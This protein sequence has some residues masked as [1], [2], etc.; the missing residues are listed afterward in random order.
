[1]SWG[2]EL[3]KIRRYLRD[4]NGRLW[5]DA[6]LMHI[7]NDI[8]Q[9][10]QHKTMAL[11]DIATQR[12][13]GLYQ[14]AYQFD[15]EWRFLSTDL[16]Q[17]YQCLTIYD[18][19]V[20][21]HRWEAQQMSG[22]AADVSDYG[23][24]FTQPWE[25][26]MGEIPGD[27]IKFRF[28]SN[29]RTLKYIAYDEK[30]IAGTTKKQIQATDPSYVVTQGLPLA[31]YPYDETDNSY[32]LYPRPATSWVNEISGDGVALYAD[33]DSEDTTTGVIA[34]R[35]GSTDSEIGI[36]V[37]IVDATSSVFMVYSV[38]PTDM[39]TVSDESDFP[40][41]MLKYIRHGTV[42]RAYG[43]NTD[44][45]IQS[46][47]DYWQ[48]RYALGI[49]FCKRYLRSRRQDRDYRLTTPGM[50]RR[51]LRHPRLPDHYPALDP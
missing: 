5:S 20:M 1:M 34:I 31:F 7:Y 23:I 4:P 2:S 15:W 35:T 50:S 14:F 49:Q 48:G 32:V 43:A 25:A 28:P 26:F 40:D 46:L 16:S 3:V 27:V 9:D 37:D 41:F 24:H 36:P 38:T 8:Q 10:F 18:D 47:A 42:S 51:R 19:A 30:P 22:I 12:V 13:P 45:K 33:G 17:F 6:M 29:L 39:R 11:E 21:C 44:G